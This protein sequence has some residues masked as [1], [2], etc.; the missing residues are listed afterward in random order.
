MR[1]FRSPSLAPLLVVAAASLLVVRSARADDKPRIRAVTPSGE[2]RGKVVDVA[3]EGSNLYP[4]DDVSTSR[5]E[6]G[7]VVTGTP[8]ASKIVVRLTIPE[9]A[10]AGPVPIT[11]KTKTGVVVTEKF[12]VRLRAPVV[13][14]LKPDVLPRGAEYDLVATG[15]NL[16]LAG[17]D[18]RVSAEAPLTVKIVGRPTDKDFKIHVVVPADAP[19]GRK[20]ITF[21]NDDGK[22]STTVVVALAPPVVSKPVSLAVDRG[23]ERWNSPSRGRTSAPPD[24]SSSASAIPR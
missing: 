11:I 5:G 8:N 24:P 14:K 13:T 16:V 19:P 3:I 4:N 21:E 18:P 12:S 9:G 15:T 2:V 10:A 7:L 22:V 17:L 1:R 20:S 6:I 23:G